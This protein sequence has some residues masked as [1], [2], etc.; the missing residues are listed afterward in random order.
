MASS[1]PLVGE[2]PPPEVVFSQLPAQLNLATEMGRRKID[3][4]ASRISKDDPQ[5]LESFQ[6]R[7][8]PSGAERVGGS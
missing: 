7:L 1:E 5:L 3:Q 2:M 6:D 4:P 8:Y